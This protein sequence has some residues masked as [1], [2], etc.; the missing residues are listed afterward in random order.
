MGSI[1][2]STMGRSLFGVTAVTT[3]AVAA[4][5]A[6]AACAPPGIGHPPARTVG[7]S[8]GSASSGPG[9]PADA[10]PEGGDGP[11]TFRVLCASSH[12]LADDPIVH[13]NMPGASHLHQFFGNATTDAA[14][15]AS[16]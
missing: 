14:S 10:G 13:P 8:A 16:S 11:A 4:I 1:R 12:V 3:V 2:G 15:S 5:I 9:G 6:V 7:V